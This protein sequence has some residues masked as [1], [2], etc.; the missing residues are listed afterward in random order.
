[1]G[2]NPSTINISLYRRAQKIGISQLIAEQA[3]NH[4]KTAPKRRAEERKVSASPQD[5][6]AGDHHHTTAHIGTEPGETPPR[7]EAYSNREKPFGPDGLKG[8]PDIPSMTIPIPPCWSS[9]KDS[10]E[11][12]H[13]QDPHT[14]IPREYMHTRDASEAQSHEAWGD[15]GDIAYD[16]RSTF[17][18]HYANQSHAFSERS[19]E[20]LRNLK[21]HRS[22][23]PSPTSGFP[24]RSK[25]ISPKRGT[26]P[27]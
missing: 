21:S 15:F 27:T 25:N 14:P 2:W 16:A 26:Y 19:S 11:P 23:S 10:R 5:S 9:N 20:N 7:P 4:S 22:V 6:S 3:H 8:V 18:Q 17:Y 12:V 13:P 1:M 24:V